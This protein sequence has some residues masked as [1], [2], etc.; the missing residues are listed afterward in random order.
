MRLLTDT[1]YL[2]P[3][4]GV[5]V[6]GFPRL[7][8]RDLQRSGHT[9]SICTISIFELAAIGAKF[10]ARR[11]L[12]QR[13]VEDG[14]RA[15]LH[16]P[17][18]GHVPFEGPAVIRRALAVREEIKDFVDCLLLS[19]AAAMTDALV[20]EDEELQRAGSQESIRSKLEPTSPTFAVCGL[21]SISRVV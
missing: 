2:L 21:R 13:R 18:L 7:A 8:V 11:K 19:S 14:L 17:N 15:I 16:D 3:A 10:V 6:R 5:S 20:T 12:K 9:L 4:I 1:T